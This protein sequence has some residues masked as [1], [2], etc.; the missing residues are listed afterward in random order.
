[1]HNNTGERREEGNLCN[2]IGLKQTCFVVMLQLLAVNFTF[3]N[4]IKLQNKVNPSHFSFFFY[5]ALKQSDVC[6]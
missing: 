6:L 1:M 3:L 2:G 4:I 5:Q